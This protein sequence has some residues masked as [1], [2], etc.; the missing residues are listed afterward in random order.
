[1]SLRLLFCRTAKAAP[2]SIVESSSRAIQLAKYATESNELASNPLKQC[3]RGHLSLGGDDC[4]DVVVAWV[5]NVGGHW[6]TLFVTQ[7]RI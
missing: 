4:A 3:W 2:H 7:N 1:M 5:S 6:G